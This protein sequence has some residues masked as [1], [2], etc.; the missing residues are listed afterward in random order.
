MQM[1]NYVLINNQTDIVDNVVVWDGNTQD[2]TPP[3]SHTALPQATTPRLIWVQDQQ[4]QA[5]EQVL[6]T[7][8]GSIGDAWDGQK[9][10]QPQP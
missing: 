3:A 7:G 1:E 10:I 5:W 2:W 4:T 6:V 9:L 8:G